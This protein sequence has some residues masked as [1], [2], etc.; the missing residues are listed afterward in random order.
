[1]TQH[2]ID[3]KSGKDEVKYFHPALEPILKDTYGIICYQEQNMMIAREIA[4]FTEQEADNLRKAMGKKLADLMA[5]VKVSF[6]EG[7]ERKNIVTKQEAEQIF[8][9]IEASNR[10]LF[11]KSHGVAYG[12]NAYWSALCK[13]KS[14][15][16][17]YEVY[18]NHARRK[19]DTQEEIRGLIYDSK[20]HNVDVLPPRLGNLYKDFTIHRDKVYFGIS[21]I[22][23]IGESESDKI[24]SLISNNIKELDWITILSRFAKKIN[25]RAFNAMISCGVFSNKLN[26]ISRN[27]MLFEYD[28]WKKLT[29]RE[30]DFICNNIETTEDLSHHI[31]VLINNFKVNKT[32]LDT[33]LGLKKLLDNPP[34]DLTD[35]AGWLAEKEEYYM[36]IP[37]TCSAS[38]MG[39]T[40][41]INA[42][43]KEIH[44]GIVKGPANLGVTINGL[45][46]HVIKKEGKNKGK[47]MAFLSVSDHS[48]ILDSVIIFPDSYD[49]YKK[50]LYEGNT[51]ILIGKPSDS[52]DGFIVDKVCQI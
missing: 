44:Q 37:M 2:Y 51:V 13:A 14:I 22:K 18:L 47:K 42:E 21:L 41:I 35:H 1:M 32:R 16:K 40:D 12:L 23:D 33:L 27:R 43:C 31:N 48:A 8:E 4:G 38:D 39:D 34:L 9:W 45:R 19:P 30:I 17:F 5:K 25:K 52:K 50:M 46:E 3:R 15:H 6:I 29:E 10:Y 28:V 11:N 26:T 49:Q 24:L 20:I 36:G 7:A